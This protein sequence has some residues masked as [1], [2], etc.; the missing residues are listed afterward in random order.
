MMFGWVIIIR[1]EGRRKKGGREGGREGEKEGGK[2]GRWDG[3]VIVEGE[4][5]K[6]RE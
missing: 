2:K 5:D 4:R 3:V 1:G 6:V